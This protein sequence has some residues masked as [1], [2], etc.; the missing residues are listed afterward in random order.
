ML[1]DYIDIGPEP[2][3]QEPINRFPLIRASELTAK[4]VVIQWL[5]ADILEAGSLNLLF[6]EPAAG[7]SLFALDWAFCVAA[8][9]SWEGKKTTKS[10]V[11]VIAGEGFAGLSRRLM[12]LEKKYG[13]K[14]PDGLFISQRPADLIDEKA[15]QWVADSIVSLCPNPGLIIIDTLHRNMTGDENSS[16]DIG[17]F[18]A[19]I[20]NHLKP[21]GAAVLVVHHSGHGQKDRSRGS[22]SIRAAMDGEFGSTKEGCNVV[23]ACHKSKD[24]EAFRPMQ[25]TLTPVALDWCDE[26][27]A[28]LTSVYLEHAGEAR[29]VEAKPKLSSRDEIALHCLYQAVEQNG[30]PPSQSIIK[31]FSG[32]DAG[33]T[34]KVVNIDYWKDLFYPRIDGENPDTRQKA[35]KRTRDKLFNG[36]MICN[37]D[38]YWW[39][40]ND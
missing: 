13:L 27:G 23:L 1:P 39:P 21:L 26:D 32:F 35:F 4:P 37:F 14:A 19:N 25:F 10:D 3:S 20:D 17:Q 16:A 29:P 31:T 34:K 12:A 30:V 36:Q 38:N 33:S 18:V 2:A 11:V 5:V 7:K 6:G 24:F 28:A 22:S 40:I 15:A 9:R 8:G